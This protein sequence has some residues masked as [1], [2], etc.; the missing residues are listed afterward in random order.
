VDD[1]LRRSCI[2]RIV[3]MLTF[4][5]I[6]FCVMIYAGVALLLNFSGFRESFPGISEQILLIGFLAGFPLVI[7][8]A[9]LVGNYLH[10]IFWRWLRKH[11][12]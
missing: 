6:I 3:G 7:M 4:S 12:M 11:K 5:L 1:A 8:I 10:G 2:G 9:G